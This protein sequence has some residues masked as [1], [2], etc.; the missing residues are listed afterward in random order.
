MIFPHE[1]DEEDL[2]L[3]KMQWALLGLEAVKI[4]TDE[5]YVSKGSKWLMEYNHYPQKGMWVRNLAWD[6]FE[7]KREELARRN[8]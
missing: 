4:S 3:V 5:L 2:E 7:E 1:I 8:R 6:H